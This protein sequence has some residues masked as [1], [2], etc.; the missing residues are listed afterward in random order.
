[1]ETSWT[2]RCST[3]R[4]TSWAPKSLPDVPGLGDGD[5][6]AAVA[7]LS[8]VRCVETA[9]GWLLVSPVRGKQL[10]G[11]AE[12]SG[13]PEWLDELRHL[14]DPA[15]R[16]SRVYE[17]FAGVARSETT[18]TW[19]ERLESHDVPAAPVLTLDQHLNDAQVEHNQTYLVY[20][21]PQLGR[22]RQPR[23]PARWLDREVQGEPDGSPGNLNMGLT[24]RH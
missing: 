21:H 15:E 4:L 18:S 2:F 5:R 19:L 16:T 13:H 12:A 17:L 23:Y 24:E 9:D 10:K 3:P 1:M 6:P 14:S 22:I 20:E 7:Q 11:L 8:A